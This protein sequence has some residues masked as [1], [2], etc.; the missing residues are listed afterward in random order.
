MIYQWDIANGIEEGAL[1]MMEI[2]VSGQTEHA[3]REWKGGK[4]QAHQVNQSESVWLW[5]WEQRVHEGHGNILS[6][7]DE[8]LSCDMEKM[9]RRRANIKDIVNEY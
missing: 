4:D 1:P 7:N 9:E 6:R 2:E 3:G 8:S 5:K